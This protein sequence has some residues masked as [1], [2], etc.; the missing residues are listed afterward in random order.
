MSQGILAKFP[1]ICVQL[2]QCIYTNSTAACAMAEVSKVGNQSG[3]LGSFESRM[4]GRR[5]YSDASEDVR[6]YSKNIS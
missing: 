6:S 2:E 5:Q 4:A 1:W 3:E